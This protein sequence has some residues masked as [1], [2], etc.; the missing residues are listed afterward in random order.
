MI[1]ASPELTVVNCY[2][3]DCTLFR[4]TLAHTS[5]MK[6]E[7]QVLDRYGPAQIGFD[8]LSQRSHRSL[9]AGFRHPTTKL[10][11]PAAHERWSI[12]L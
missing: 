5:K 6:F 10:V 8:R 1:T 4:V 2:Q 9:W 3:P 7:K 12:G 11:S